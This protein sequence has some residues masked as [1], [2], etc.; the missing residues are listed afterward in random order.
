[1]LNEPGHE[2]VRA[3][4]DLAYIHSVNVAEVIG[5]LVREGVPREEAEQMIEEL[6]LDI[7]EEFG[8]RQAAVC[9]ELLARRQG[10]S[11]GDCVCLTVAACVGGTTVTADRQW[12][13]LQGQRLGNGEIR[14]QVI[15]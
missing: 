1:M 10:L 8:V 12:K 4:I 14:V 5:K 9:G 6:S 13:E 2:K 11:L 7:D 3:V 15:R